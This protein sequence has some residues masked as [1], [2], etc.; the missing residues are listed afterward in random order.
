MVSPAPNLQEVAQIV[1]PRTHICSA[2]ETR[3]FIRLR[4][5]VAPYRHAATVT[6]GDTSSIESLAAE[7]AAQ[8][9]A[10]AE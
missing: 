5:R 10:D 1:W 7:V 2:I 8:I 6:N 4:D 9:K 3:Q